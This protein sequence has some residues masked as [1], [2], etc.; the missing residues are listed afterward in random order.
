MEIKQ[1]IVIAQTG[2]LKQRVVFDGEGKCIVGD[3]DIL[4]SCDDSTITVR[5]MSGEAITAPGD[6]AEVLE[7]FPNGKVTGVYSSAV[8]DSIDVEEDFISSTEVAE[9]PETED[10]AEAPST[11]D[12]SWD[13][14]HDDWDQ[15]SE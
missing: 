14:G 11:S 2:S 15:G 4:S 8:M 5:G 13:S 1:V 6:V 10:T 9:D 3:E 12:S 7:G